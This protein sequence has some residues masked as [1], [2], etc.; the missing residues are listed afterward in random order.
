MLPQLWP[1]YYSFKMLCLKMASTK[2]QPFYLSLKVFSIHFKLKVPM[3]FI[4]T[5]FWKSRCLWSHNECLSCE[6]AI[7]CV[8]NHLITH[9]SHP[10]RSEK[11]LQTEHGGHLKQNGHH[12]A[13]YIL[14]FLWD[15]WC[16]VIFKFHWKLSK[17]IHHW[18]RWIISPML[19]QFSNA[20][21]SHP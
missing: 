7:E 20:Y 5:I 12:S 11:G 19:I 4:P 16:N 1:T 21:M 10:H 9:L 8:S 2:C 13:D 14:N 17:V 3:F 18:F 6:C 15:R